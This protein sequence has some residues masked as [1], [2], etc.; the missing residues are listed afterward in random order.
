MP[1]HL[2]TER[3]VAR[4]AAEISSFTY[5]VIRQGL[6]TE[7]YS[8]YLAFLDLKTPPNEL[9]IP[10]DGKGPEI[11]WVKR[12]EVGKTTAHLLPDYAQNSTTFPCFNDALFLSGPREI[13]IGKSVDFINSILEEEIKIL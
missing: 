13:S 10:Y 8:L 12:D 4:F 2:D 7:S 11:S 5:T 9:I 1:A 3:Y 6:Y